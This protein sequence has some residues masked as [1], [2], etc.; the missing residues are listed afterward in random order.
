M[1]GK[2]EWNDLPASVRAYVDS[3]LG[4]VVAAWPVMGGNNCQV[5]LRVTTTAGADLFL[6]GSEVSRA[7]SKFLVR[8][9]DVAVVVGG[10]VAPS[11]A[12]R[13]EAA[14]WS[15]LAFEFVDGRPARFEAG[16]ADLALLLD[17]L[18][19][20][21]SIDVRS[22]IVP[23]AEQRWASYVFDPDLRRAVI[24]SKLCHADF[25]PDNVIISNGR[26]VLV[27]WAWATAGPAWLDLVIAPVWLIGTGG[28]TAREAEV[29]AQ[30]SPRWANVSPA[31]LAGFA[32]ANAR[33][34]TDIATRN[35]GDWSRILSDAARSWAAHL[36]A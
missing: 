4:G 30:R 22:G 11:L 33:M 20:T 23:T 31:T 15:L 27:D 19:K 36:R 17:T 25:N 3:R 14:G 7:E 28:H 18:D 24:G 5:S 21:C 2:C 32:E 6:K 9:V 26:A 12:W 8:E 16:S 34:W 35:P 13:G 29:W 10:T 1:V